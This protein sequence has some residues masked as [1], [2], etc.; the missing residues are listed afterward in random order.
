MATGTVSSV[1]GDV[2][3]LIQTTTL[4]A[5]ANATLSSIS[6]YKKIMVVGKN[7][8]NTNGNSVLAV[9]FNA[10]STVGNYGGA[11]GLSYIPA[12]VSNGTTAS[13]WHFFVN[14]VDKAIPHMIETTGTTITNKVYANPAAITSIAVYADTSFGTNTFASGTIYFYGIAA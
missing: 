9:R 1:T 12:T 3:Q 7:V 11:D 10:D 5:S 6:G 8:V 2:Y 14:D 13:A 4:S